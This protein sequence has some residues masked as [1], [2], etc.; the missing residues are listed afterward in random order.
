MNEEEIELLNVN[1][2]SIHD[3]LLGNDKAGAV[4]E[5]KFYHLPMPLHFA[6]KHRNQGKIESYKWFFKGF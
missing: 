4:K 6:I 1:N 3:F 5:Q 2:Y